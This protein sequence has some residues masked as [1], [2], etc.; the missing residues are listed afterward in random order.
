MESS[1]SL[2]TFAVLR[3]REGKLPR[4]QEGSWA[5][6]PRHDVGAKRKPDPKTGLAYLKQVTVSLSS[7]RA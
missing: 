6:C 4:S 2:K 7:D 1:C 3:L 5:R